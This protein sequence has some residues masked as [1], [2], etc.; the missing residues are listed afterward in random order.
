MKSIFPLVDST[1]TVSHFHYALSFIKAHTKKNSLY[2]LNKHTW[3]SFHRE[4]LKTQLWKTA[5]FGRLWKLRN[6]IFMYDEI[7]WQHIWNIPNHAKNYKRWLICLL[8]SLS[9]FHSLFFTMWMK[10]FFGVLLP[11]NQFIGWKMAHEA[12]FLNEN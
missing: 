9:T 6:F 8:F 7:V 5:H 11:T 10:W 2:V 3:S 12:Y 4:T 1:K